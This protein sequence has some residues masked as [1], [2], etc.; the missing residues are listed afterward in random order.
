MNSACVVVAAPGSGAWTT[1]LVRSAMAGHV[2]G[3]GQG[4]TLED[5]FREPRD[6][7]EGAVRRAAGAGHEVNAGALADVLTS[8]PDPLAENVFFRF[9]DRLGGVPL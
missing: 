9:L 7:A 2:G 3:G 6:A 8:D 1:C 4:L 5:C